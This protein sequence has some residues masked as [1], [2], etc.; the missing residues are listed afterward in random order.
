M[1]NNDLDKAV[2]RVTGITKRFPGV[3]ANDNIDFSLTQGEIH[4]LLGE[5]GAG[6]TT[7]MNVVYGLYTPDEVVRLLTQAGFV[8]MGMFGDYDLKP[9]HEDALEWIVTAERPLA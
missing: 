4:G 8:G 7:L 3:V 9:W 1:K 5:N 6:K 2:L